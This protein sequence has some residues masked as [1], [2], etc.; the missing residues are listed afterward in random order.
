MKIHLLSG[1]LGSGKTTAVKH[2]SRALLQQGIKTGVITNDQGIKLVD[3]DF[4]KSLN[5]P[6][7]QVVNG[8]FCCNYNDFEANIQSLIKANETEIIFAESVGSCTDIVATVL[9][10]LLHLRPDAQV[11]VSTFADVR[12][13]QMILKGS[14][15]L[16]DETVNYIYLKQLEEAGVI[17]INKIDLINKEHLAEIKQ[18]MEEKNGSKILLYQ[19]SLD[20]DNIQH[21]LHTL[22]N[23]QSAGMLQSLIIDYDIYAAGEAKLAWFD[24]ELEIYSANNNALQHAEDLIN[25]I[26]EKIIAHEYAPG[27]LKFLINGAIKISF[28]S[29]TQPAVTIKTEPAASAALLINIRVQ[30]EPE[31]IEQ[32]IA[33]AVKE[34]EMQSGCKIIVNSLSAFKPSYPHPAYRI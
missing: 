14:I 26:Y 4:F 5:V 13:L 23:Y 24:Q 33:G 34:A 18:L 8:C 32:L 15:D 28:T 12:L 16:F 9:K 31:I 20:E 19:N 2:V 27:H 22:N 25:N 17:V 11:T 30:T 3:G 10:P 6:N 29:N 21:W 7:R 1:F